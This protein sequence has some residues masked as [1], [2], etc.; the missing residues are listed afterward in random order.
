[1]LVPRRVL[2]AHCPNFEQIFDP[3]HWATFE[4]AWVEKRVTLLKTNIDT[5]HD[6]SEN[7]S[8]FKHGVILGSYARFQ[9]CIN[10][11]NFFQ[12]ERSLKSNAWRRAVI[13]KPRLFSVFNITSVDMEQK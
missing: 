11:A 7:V 13:R 4:V 6:G 2:V 10:F 1:M 9:G 3:Q 8:P 5:K 12:S